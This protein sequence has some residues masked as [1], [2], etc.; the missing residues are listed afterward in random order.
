ML[1]LKNL[2]VKKYAKA[3]H[4]SWGALMHG[5]LLKSD[6]GESGAGIEILRMLERAN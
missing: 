4:N 2:K 1:R 5:V 6:D 3:I